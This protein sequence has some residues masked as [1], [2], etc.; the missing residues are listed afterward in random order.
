MKERPDDGHS[1][2]AVS[3]MMS[4]AHDKKACREYALAKKYWN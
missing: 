4:V 2:D 3:E 1:T